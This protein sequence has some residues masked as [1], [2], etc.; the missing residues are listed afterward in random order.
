M[1]ETEVVGLTGFGVFGFDW[2][3][4][5][6]ASADAVVSWQTSEDGLYDKVVLRDDLTWSDGEPITA[7]DVEFSFRAIM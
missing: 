1:A 5:P 7:H 4:N 3:F 2:E 6:L